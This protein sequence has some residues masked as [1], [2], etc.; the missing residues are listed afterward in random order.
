MLVKV[1]LETVRQLRKSKNV[2]VQDI[3]HALNLKTMSA[4]YRKELGI[5][6]FSLDEAKVLADM[7]GT[8]I[9]ELF[10]AN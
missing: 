4:Y 10:F 2:H 9:E 7:L 1:N 8:S 3:I 6:D 5:N